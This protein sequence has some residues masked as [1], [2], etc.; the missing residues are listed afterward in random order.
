[1]SCIYISGLFYKMLPKY[2]F[3]LLTQNLKSIKG[4]TKQ[5]E[6]WW[7]VRM[8]HFIPIL[9]IGKYNMTAYFEN[10][11]CPLIY[12][13]QKRAW[14]DISTCWN[15]FNEVCRTTYHPVLLI[16]DNAPKHF[17]GRMLWCYFKL[18]M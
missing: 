6:H 18:S 11:K 3:V 9:L 13:A 2:G 5:K 7:F 10:P 4:K 15:W 14:M 17:K 12:D 16:M 1:M 8:P